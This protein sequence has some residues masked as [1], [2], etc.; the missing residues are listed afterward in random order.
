MQAGRP[1]GS[2]HGR[3]TR[4]A[5]GVL[6]C[7]PCIACCP[8]MVR[9]AG[10]HTSPSSAHI[11]WGEVSTLSKEHERRGPPCLGA[12]WSDVDPPGFVRAAGF[13]TE[14]A[15]GER[16]LQDGGKDRV[17]L[18]GKP[19]HWRQAAE[20]SPALQVLGQGQAP[21]AEIDREGGGGGCLGLV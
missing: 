5:P 14:V 10:K 6:V 12:G 21:N 2:R 1:A 7:A 20:E 19:V 4:G 16:H 15:V 3:I 11:T 17:V 13:S 18:R 8:G 9:G